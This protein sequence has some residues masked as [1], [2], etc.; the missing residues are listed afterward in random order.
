METHVVNDPPQPLAR[1][2]FIDIDEDDD[3]RNAD[4]QPSTPKRAKP[5]RDFFDP[6][7]PDIWTPVS[8]LKELLKDAIS[9]SDFLG[10]HKIQMQ[11][12]ELLAYDQGSLNQMVVEAIAETWSETTSAGDSAADEVGEEKAVMGLLQAAE[13][14]A[15]LRPDVTVICR[16]NQ[17]LRRAITTKTDVM[18]K[19]ESLEEENRRLRSENEALLQRLQF[20]ENTGSKTIDKKRTPSEESKSYYPFCTPC[21][22]VPFRKGSVF[23]EIC[24]EPAHNQRLTSSQIQGLTCLHP[25]AYAWSKSGAKFNG[26]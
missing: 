22:M 21:K 2:G 9:R 6:A 13:K 10:A 15:T 17:R 8:P 20:K 11:M 3:E 1:H 12:Q 5:S 14:D 25:L 16:A 23:V 24:M 19:L 7:S 18:G 4:M 26:R